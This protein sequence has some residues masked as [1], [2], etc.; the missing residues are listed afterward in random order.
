MRLPR[1]SSCKPEGLFYLSDMSEPSA[2]SIRQ[3]FAEVPPTYE[4]INHI[5]TLG[6]DVLWRRR[7]ARLA[8][9]GGAQWADLCTGTGETAACL[10]RLAPQGTTIHAVDF[11]LPMLEVAR[12]K[13][14]A[15]RIAWVSA[16]VDALPFPDGTFDRMTM[17]FATR[18]LNSD[19]TVLVQRFAEIRRVLKSGGSF[20]NLETSQPP[21]RPIRRLRD[22]YVRLSVAS[23]G[24]RISGSRT[25]Y[26]Y[27]AKSIVSFYTADELTGILR[28]AGFDQV[29]FR[30]LLCG[31]AAI[32]RGMKQKCAISP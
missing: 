7:A 6:L 1:F 32:H 27:L 19:R 31:V 12:R 18:N 3:I 22:L 20:V 14:E 11:S 15:D 26:A 10:A 24:S 4:R 29:T 16:S 8:A 21:W 25:A 23:I 28:E 13:P 5:L 9:T 2:P 30:R 17:S